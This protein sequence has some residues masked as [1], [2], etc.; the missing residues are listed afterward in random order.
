MSQVFFHKQFERQYAVLDGK[1]RDKFKAR[2]K[3]FINDEFDPMLNNHPLRGR[4][5]GYRSIN[6]TGDMRALYKMKKEKQFVFIYI[7]NHS[8]LYKK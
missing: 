5:E 8:K 3:I 2:M 6:I 7:G 1:L 4:Y